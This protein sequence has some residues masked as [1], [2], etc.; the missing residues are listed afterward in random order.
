MHNR[1]TRKCRVLPT[2]SL[3]LEFKTLIRRF[4]KHAKPPSR[5]QIPSL[6][7]ALGL[8]RNFKPQGLMSIKISVVCHS[9]IRTMPS[10]IHKCHGKIW[11]STYLAPNWHVVLNAPLHVEFDPRPIDDHKVASIL[12]LD[13]MRFPRAYRLHHG[14]VSSMSDWPSSGVHGLTLFVDK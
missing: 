9:W 1:A 14:V 13:P 6:P 11:P 10:M 7:L 5:L 4:V 3:P 12:A 2:P 8:D